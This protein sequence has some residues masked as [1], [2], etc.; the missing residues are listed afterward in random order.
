MR[1]GALLEAIQSHR[2][3]CPVTGKAP[4]RRVRNQPPEYQSRGDHSLSLAFSRVV[5]VVLSGW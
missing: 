5:C 4:P 2:S 3:G 1:A